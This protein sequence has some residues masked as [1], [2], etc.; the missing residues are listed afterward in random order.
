MNT[1]QQESTS[2]AEATINTYW[3]AISKAVEQVRDGEADRIEGKGWK[4]YRVV[5][6]IRI[7]LTNE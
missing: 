1:I 2:M 6:L 4:V 7:D 5:K 3:S